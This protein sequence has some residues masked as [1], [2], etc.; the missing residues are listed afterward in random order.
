MSDWEKLAGLPLRVESYELT[1]H[2]REYGY[3]TRPSTLV[4]LH[5]DGQEGIG[6]DVVYDVLDQIAHRD[7]GRPT[8]SPG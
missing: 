7:P 2:D 8:T 6:E 1:G 3:F 5:G 4:H